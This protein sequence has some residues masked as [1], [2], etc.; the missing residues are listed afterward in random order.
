MASREPR[1]NISIPAAIAK[2]VRTVAQS[3]G[4]SASRI[5]ADLVDRGLDAV[6][7]EKT[8]FYGLAARL[9]N[10]EGDERE[11]LKAEL[12]DLTFG[13][14]MIQSPARTPPVLASL[15][16]ILKGSRADYRKHL[17]AKYR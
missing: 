17:S 3:R 6:D 11:R 1:L 13:P 8:R 5:V 7:R 16:G 14:A 10:S 15:R 12:A 9:E 2:R 4:V